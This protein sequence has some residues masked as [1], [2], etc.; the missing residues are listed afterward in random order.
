MI[1]A[2]SPASTQWCRKTLL[3][4]GP[5]VRREPEGDVGH[6]E[7]GEH[8]GQLALDGADAVDGLARRV[9]PLGLAGGER[10]GERVEDQL[11]GRETELVARE[12]V[13]AAR[14]LELALG[15]ARHPLLVDGERDDAGAV[16]AHRAAAP[17]RSGRARSRG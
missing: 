1:A 10:E 2:S 15:G 16:V 7:H 9:D 3:S 11:I 17:R 12:V 5:R 13:D 14:D 4:T 6:A 8:A